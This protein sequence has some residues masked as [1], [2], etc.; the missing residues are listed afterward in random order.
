MN[1]KLIRIAIAFIPFALGC[2]ADMRKPVAEWDYAD[3]EAGVYF[4]LP[5]GWIF[6][7]AEEF[8]RRLSHGIPS[9]AH[10]YAVRKATIQ[11]DYADS[12]L[13]FSGPPPAQGEPKLSLR[14]ACIRL[15]RGA[16]LLSES[17]SRRAGIFSGERE[18]C[19]IEPNP[20]HGLEGE[21]YLL[22]SRGGLLFV[23][24][25][26]PTLPAES[27]VQDALDRLVVVQ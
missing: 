22:M 12:V 11:F 1:S 5:P 20:E 18:F 25:F 27:L 4:T 26:A 21:L 13:V 23:M 19:A 8:V 24:T 16:P 6:G 3:D 15:S 7:P 9:R 14:E 10:F 17:E 2:A